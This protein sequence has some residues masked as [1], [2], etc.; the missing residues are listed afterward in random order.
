MQAL[1]A[2][3]TT[4]VDSIVPIAQLG[5][6]ADGTAVLAK[7]GEQLIEVVQLSFGPDSPRWAV[8]EA[9]LRAAGAVDHP[10]VRTVLSLEPAPPAVMLEGDNSP[11]LAELV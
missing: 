8:L 11:P 5:V 2:P 7:K 9:R 3:S 1:L 4:L 10:G 6:G